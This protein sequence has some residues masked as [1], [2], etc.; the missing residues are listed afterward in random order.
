MVEKFYWKVNRLLCRLQGFVLNISGSFSVCMCVCVC[1]YV[2]S[3]KSDE[4][5][6]LFHAYQLESYKKWDAR[7]RAQMHA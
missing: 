6:H 5:L 4:F 2:C 3:F 7:A 1:M